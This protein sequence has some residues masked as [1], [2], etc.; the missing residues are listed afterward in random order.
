MSTIKTVSAIRKSLDLFYPMLD[1]FST[2]SSWTPELNAAFILKYH[3]IF[4]V[5]RK[6][7]IV[8]HSGTSHVTD[9][10][11]RVMK[12]VLL[13]E[14]YSKFVPFFEERADDGM[15]WRALAY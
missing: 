5:V 7:G 3:R 6:R 13:L 15:F 2:I 11:K 10:C 14:W 8:C 12:L 9:V 1:E 4:K